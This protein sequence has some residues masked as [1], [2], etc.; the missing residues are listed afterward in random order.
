MVV[1]VVVA[2]AMSALGA[3]P[4][5]AGGG[6]ARDQYGGFESIDA[7]STGRFRVEQIDGVWWFVD[8]DGHGFFSSGVN[9]VNIAADFSLV[10][11]ALALPRP[12]A[13]ASTVPRLRGPTATT[14]RL[15]RWGVNTIGAF[16]LPTLF[17]WQMP[18]TVLLN[19]TQHAPRVSKLTPTTDTVRDFLGPWFDVAAR[20]HAKDAA[21]GCAADPWCIGVFTDNEPAWGRSV[22][23][24]RLPPLVHARR[25][26]DA[27][28]K[29]GTAALPRTP[30]RRRRERLQRGVGN[31]AADF[32]DFQQLPRLPGSP[33]APSADQLADELAF[34][35]LRRP[36]IFQGH[37]RRVAF[38]EQGAPEPRSPL[39][40]APDARPTSTRSRAG[41]STSSR[42]TTT[43]SLPQ[44]LAADAANFA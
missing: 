44:V 5:D 34:R 36:P 28:A 11:G 32:D 4:A 17:A 33:A 2:L 12:H 40:R 38:G 10:V 15:R 41:T 13:R 27:S 6:E 7:D 3:G 29:V 30:V 8:P 23:Q 42:S 43:S 18:Y 26:P 35:K 1:P 25:V 39:R 14:K 21:A 37:G 20:A 16:S 9:N 19:F 22:R 31:A 24:S